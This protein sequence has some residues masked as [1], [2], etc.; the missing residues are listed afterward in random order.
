MWV[1]VCLQVFRRRGAKKLREVQG[2]PV[3]RLGDFGVQV[4]P[5]AK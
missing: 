5:T 3:Y 2:K 1:R 4:R